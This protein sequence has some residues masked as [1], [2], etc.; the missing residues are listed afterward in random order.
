MMV[1]LVVNA[2]NDNHGAYRRF[3]AGFTWY[4]NG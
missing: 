1:T 4:D 2:V 3:C